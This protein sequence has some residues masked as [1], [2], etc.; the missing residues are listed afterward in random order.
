VGVVACAVETAEGGEADVANHKIVHTQGAE[1]QN[2]Y[3]RQK[4]EWGQGRLAGEGEADSGMGYKEDSM[5][6]VE[7]RDSEAGRD[8]H[9]DDKGIVVGGMQAGL[10][11]ATD[12]K[13][14]PWVVHIC[15]GK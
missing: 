2:I 7:R 9:T 15:W 6:K 13:P 1:A 3:H 4:V 8:V 11:A 12:Q 14:G 5:N 10:G